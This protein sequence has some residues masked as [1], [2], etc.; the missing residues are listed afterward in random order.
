MDT[1]FHRTGALRGCVAGASGKNG[2]E[3][4]HVG[5]A[6]RRQQVQSPRRYAL[7]DGPRPVIPEHSIDLIP[8]VS[9]GG[10]PATLLCMLESS[11]V[12]WFCM[13]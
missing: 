13:R 2:V 8:I 6:R 11:Q 5:A 10:C 4:V 9:D 1:V 3:A 12:P 7:R